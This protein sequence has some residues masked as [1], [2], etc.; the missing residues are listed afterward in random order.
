MENAKTYKSFT[1]LEVWQQA[2]TFK[3]AIYSLV[4]SLPKTEKYSLE[5]QII[6]SCR[7][8]AAN[9]SEGY[10]RYTYKEQIRF[11]MNA[12]GSLYE[13]QNHLIDAND[14]N[15]ISA[16]TLT[17]YTEQVKTVERLLNGYIGWLRKRIEEDK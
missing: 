4:K 12:R 10:G 1:D 7:S 16:E 5:D 8:V 11:C 2:R 17:E 3:L 14:C 6:R 9:I 13:T 15:Y